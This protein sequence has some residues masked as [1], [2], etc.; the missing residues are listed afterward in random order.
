[1]TL[2]V[3]LVFD[4][5]EGEG[6]HQASL[7]AVDHAA[8]SLGLDLDLRVVRTDTIDDDYL[9]A[10]PQALFIGPGTPYRE[11][12]AAEEVIRAARER[13]VPLVGT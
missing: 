12:Q 13:G 7:D 2:R 4:V 11:P 1:M 10:L 9:A 6:Y 8:Q 5:P 3:D